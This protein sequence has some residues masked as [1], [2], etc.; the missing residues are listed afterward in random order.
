MPN[1][2]LHW[3][4]IPQGD[5]AMPK[6]LRSSTPILLGALIKC[7]APYFVLTQVIVSE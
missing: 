3:M 1:N 6:A 5:G 4:E 7:N 2:P